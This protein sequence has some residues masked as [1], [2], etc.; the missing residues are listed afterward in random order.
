MWRINAIILSSRKTLITTFMCD[1][2]K[3]NKT[4]AEL[5]DIFH[6]CKDKFASETDPSDDL[7]VLTFIE[8]MKSEEWLEPIQLLSKDGMVLDGVH[9]GI[10]YLI[11]IQDGVSKEKLPDV[12]INEPVLA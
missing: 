5:V 11:F 4:F 7:R 3:K 9:R 10:A 2:S 8:D 12:L 1:G 6:K